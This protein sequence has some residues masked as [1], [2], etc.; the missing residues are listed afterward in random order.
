MKS[1]PHVDPSFNATN[2]YSVEV[3]IH[4]FLSSFPSHL[5]YTSL[6]SSSFLFKQR[7]QENESQRQWS[8]TADLKNGR[9][10]KPAFAERDKKQTMIDLRGSRQTG[11][12][13]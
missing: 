10:F 11:L 8:G 9:R 6:S 12:L 3:Y 5:L 4:W 7:L 13:K 1:R 2:L